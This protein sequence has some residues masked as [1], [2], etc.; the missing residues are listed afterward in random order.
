MRLRAVAA[1]ACCLLVSTAGCAKSPSSESVA[2]GGLRATTATDGLEFSVE[3]S[4]TQVPSSQG[5]SVRLVLTNTGTAVVH[6]EDLKMGW[7]ASIN[8]TA[9]NA[10][11]V[12]VG[13]GG[14]YAEKRHPETL[15]PGETTT[16]VATLRDPSPGVY[17]IRGAYLGTGPSG[18]TSELVV[19]VRR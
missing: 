18:K 1:L 19:R 2:Q 13:I 12:S 17:R 15:A 3:V 6:W 5:L 8:D 7:T 4:S 11:E 14:T 10:D 16:T 9:D